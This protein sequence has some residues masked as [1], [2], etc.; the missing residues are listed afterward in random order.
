MDRITAYII[1]ALLLCSCGSQSSIRKTDYIQ[2][3]AVSEERNVL[4]RSEG[5]S[6]S[7]G[8]LR[9]SLNESLVIIEEFDTARPVDPTTGTPPL[10]RRETSVDRSRIKDVRDVSASVRRNSTE[11]DISR[12]DVTV[13]TLNQDSVMPPIT[14][15]GRKGV[16]PLIKWI[17]LGTAVAAVALLLRWA[18]KHGSWG[19]LALFKSIF[20]KTN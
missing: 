10:I 15:K 8:V 11:E 13:Q 4:V 19:V 7:V 5:S 14:E 12:S 2:E 17:A 18:F 20:K 1:A 6:I 9:D 16:R 3:A